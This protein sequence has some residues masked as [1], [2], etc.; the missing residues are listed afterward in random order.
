VI[1][2]SRADETVPFADSQELLRTSGL[3]ESALIEVGTE[4]RLAD[5][6]SL[7]KMLEV[8]KGLSS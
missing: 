5:E 1:L 6:E 3:P 4:H 7:N 8:V 2:H